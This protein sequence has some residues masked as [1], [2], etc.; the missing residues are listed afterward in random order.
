[1]NHEFKKKMGKLKFKKRKGTKQGSKKQS[2]KRFR[3]EDVGFLQKGKKRGPYKQY[4]DNERDIA[5]QIVRQGGSLRDKSVPKSTLHDN[6]VSK[7]KENDKRMT[8]TP[9]QNEEMV[10][11]LSKAQKKGICI[12]KWL[13][14]GFARKI[15]GV[16]N[17][18]FSNNWFRSFCIRNNYVWR[19]G[20]QFA[21]AR[22][23]AKKDRF[24]VDSFKGLLGGYFDKYDLKAFQILNIDEKPFLIGDTRTTTLATRGQNTPQILSS[25]NSRK[26]ATLVSTISADG[27]Y[28]P[29]FFILQGKRKTGKVI[30]QVDKY[31]KEKDS[32]G[33]LRGGFALNPE[34]AFMTQKTWIEFFNFILPFLPEERPLLI[35]LDGHTSRF[36]YSFAELADRENI[37]VLVL[38]SHTST[39]LQPLDLT[40]HAI[41]ANAYRNPHNRVG[42]LVSNYFEF[43][44]V[45]CPIIENQLTE[46]AIK[47]G[48]EKAGIFPFDENSLNI[49]SENKDKV[50]E[51]VKLYVSPEK[52]NAKSELQEQTFQKRESTNKFAMSIL[53]LKLRISNE[54]YKYNQSVSNLLDKYFP[55]E[56]STVEISRVQA[57]KLLDEYLVIHQQYQTNTD[58]LKESKKAQRQ[59]IAKHKKNVL[60]ISTATTIHKHCLSWKNNSCFFD[61]IIFFLHK[62]MRDYFTNLDLENVQYDEQDDVDDILK[63]SSFR[64][65]LLQLFELM[66][67]NLENQRSNGT[68]NDEADSKKK[69]LAGMLGKKWGG[70][71]SVGRTLEDLISLFPS[72]PFSCRTFRTIRCCDE[73]EETSLLFF[74]VEKIPREECSFFIV[75]TVCRV[76]M[77]ESFHEY[78]FSE[79]SEFFIINFKSSFD[80]NSPFPKHIEIPLEGGATAKYSNIYSI[81]FYPDHFT[82]SFPSKDG[83]H[84]KYDSNKKGS[85]VEQLDS[86]WDPRE[87]SYYCIFQKVEE[88]DLDQ[89]L[90]ITFTQRKETSITDDEPTDKDDGS[91]NLEKVMKKSIYQK[92]PSTKKKTTSDRL[93]QL[94]NDFNN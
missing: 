14:F 13:V 75:N 11:E 32:N 58:K 18:K 70:F 8:L 85:Q 35:I 37:F 42:K 29:P 16:E 40:V 57:A 31:L 73:E 4:S 24:V 9:K 19:K 68:R 5:I 74:E 38:P 39:E 23:V 84:I 26:H 71:G 52:Q 33:R 76:C 54:R 17:Y 10:L 69:S 67:K 89:S 3:R 21:H 12:D 51:L 55:E 34:S 91:F 78:H 83:K 60:E 93:K 77:V 48:F 46:K 82:S 63:Q 15:L 88:D 66:D 59:D 2:N 36:S 79:L 7:P 61:V 22:Y 6:K 30:P 80:S 50:E 81:D 47:A 45:I 49:S 94:V 62:H 56:K 25:N 65:D 92:K 1:M 44:Q 86:D 72:I 53:P 87:L 27:A 43:I 90:K 20:S 64:D 41:F 28:F